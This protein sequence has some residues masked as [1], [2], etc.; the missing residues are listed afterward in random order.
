VANVLLVVN[1]T[2]RFFT[3]SSDDI[4]TQPYS[5]PGF[6]LFR[7]ALGTRQITALYEVKR[8]VIR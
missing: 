5:F 4:D 6:S 3:V 8:H 2:F 7:V 1:W